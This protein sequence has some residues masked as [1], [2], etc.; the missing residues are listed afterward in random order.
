MDILLIISAIVILL[1][2]WPRTSLTL[3]A[4]GVL[5]GAVAQCSTAKADTFEVS[6]I[7]ESEADRASMQD[8]VRDA[9]AIYSA[10]GLDLVVTYVD[11][12]TVAGHTQAAFLLD[13]VKSYR[14][15]NA[16]H[17]KADA[18]ILFTRRD[19]KIGGSDYVGIA[20]IGPACSASASAIVE[21]RNDG[22]DGAILAHELLHTVG[23]PHDA[24][25]GWLMSEG[26]SRTTSRALSPDSVLT[27]RAAGTGECMSTPAA[28][29]PPAAVQSQPAAPFST[30]AKP[31]GGGGSFDTW[32]IIFLTGLA[33]WRIGKYQGKAE[34]RQWYAH[35]EKFVRDQDATIQRMQT[36]LDAANATI[37]KMESK[38]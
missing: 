3:F 26:I 13:A 6:A 14:V 33:C 10:L 1:V 17:R 23:V 16:S 37:R 32:G 12:N 2:L 34:F 4:L 21:L 5:L 19:I 36:E 11:I 15:D 18:T 22:E 7:I 35:T 20:T 24:A 25:G 27:F 38:S 28:N 9:A 30:E 8:A 29:P 31:S